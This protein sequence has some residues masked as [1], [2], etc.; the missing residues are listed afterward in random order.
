LWALAELLDA[1]YQQT[2]SGEHHP[3][4]T[5]NKIRQADNDLRGHRK[6]HTQADEQVGKNRNYEFQQCAYDQYR[7]R[8]N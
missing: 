1:E 6:S 2:D 4:E 7:D 5:P 3:P 8:D